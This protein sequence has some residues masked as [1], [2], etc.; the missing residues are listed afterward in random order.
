MDADGDSSLLTW[1]RNVL[2]AQ[3]Q[4]IHVDHVIDQITEA[5]ESPVSN[6]AVAVHGDGGVGKTAVTYAAVERAEAHGQFTHVVWASARNTRFSALDASSAAVNS[7]YWHD[8]IAM[9]AR[10]LDCP[11]PSSQALWEGELATYL[12]RNLTNARILVVV[13]NLEFVAAADDVINRLRALGLQAPHKIVATT[14]W[15]SEM[16]DLEVRNIPV[17]P[18]TEGQ[19]YDL[20][21]LVAKSSDSDLAHARNSDLLPIF[22]ITDG[23]PFLIK[24]IV[25]RYVMSGRS[26]PRIITELT[27]VSEGTDLAQRVR[28]WLFERS[29][30]ELALRASK[31]DALSLLFSF[32]VNGRGGAMSYSELWAENSRLDPASF[33][34]L[35][36]SA[37]RLNLI[38]PS[39][40]NQR[41]SIHSLLYE[42]TCPLAHVRRD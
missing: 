16:H 10:Q 26:L 24:L 21:R 20:I 4:L 19:T 22:R 3:E 35:L 30:D 33:D 40:M 38:R 34:D 17:E 2:L 29:L 12:T 39:D 28:S 15:R 5:I 7:I 18:F 25:S 41:Y 37:C 23:N 32:C 14:R 11:L 13:D 1:R 42:H 8:L 31:R 27:A 9:V 6:S 36:E